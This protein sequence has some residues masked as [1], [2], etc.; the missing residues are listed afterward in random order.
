MRFRQS[1]LTGGDTTAFET[2]TADLLKGFYVSLN[3]IVNPLNANTNTDVTVT[4]EPHTV[5]GWDVFARLFNRYVVHGVDISLAVR[6][7]ETG[8]GYNGVTSADSRR[9]A[10]ADNF[11]II[12]GG[13]DRIPTNGFDTLGFAA[14]YGITRDEAWYLAKDFLTS[15]LPSSYASY[16]LPYT[17]AP[18]NIDIPPDGTQVTFY[19]LHSMRMGIQRTHSVTTIPL[20]EPLFTLGAPADPLFALE[21]N[22]TDA[23]NTVGTPTGVA[24]TATT[25][26]AGYAFDDGFLQAR[27]GGTDDADFEVEK[28]GI[29]YTD[30]VR[31]DSIHKPMHTFHHYFS[32]D[33]TREHAGNTEMMTHNLY[34]GD[35]DSWNYTSWMTNSPNDQ[36]YLFV[37]GYTYPMYSGGSPPEILTGTFP[38]MEIVLEIEYY[39]E[40]YDP[41]G[42]VLATTF[43]Q[44]PAPEPNLFWDVGTEEGK[45]YVRQL[46]ATMDPFYLSAD[47]AVLEDQLNT[48]TPAINEDIAV[49][50]YEALVNNLPSPAYDTAAI[51]LALIAADD[52]YSAI[53]AD[54]TV[55]TGATGWTPAVTIPP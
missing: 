31:N 11:R 37:G 36:D 43:D 8:Q 28:D 51:F 22:Q 49:A 2:H 48:D 50:I 10:I 5:E 17:D 38:T 33:V 34:S 20:S 30:T 55:I 18:S 13:I 6:V 54:G 26:N 40:F 23:A 44:L 53:R 45:E 29:M 27:G 7:T 32:N 9:L 46:R 12:V 21:M 35:P 24:W 39:C 41:K 14:Y 15:R 19:W 47:P 16:A 1:F 52:T 3:S 25:D 4:D 42:L